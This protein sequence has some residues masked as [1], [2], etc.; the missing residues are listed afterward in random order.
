[1]AFFLYRSQALVSI[2]LFRLTSYKPNS[3]GHISGDPQTLQTTNHLIWGVFLAYSIG[4][5]RC[6]LLYTLK[7]Y[8]TGMLW[9][10]NGKTQPPIQKQ[11]KNPFAG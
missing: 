8:I 6:C 3:R 7:S 10:L 5:E 1:M 2:D 9:P 4:F 11:N